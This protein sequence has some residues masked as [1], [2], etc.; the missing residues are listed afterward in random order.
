MTGFER[1]E[2]RPVIVGGGIAGLAAALFLAPEPVVL[3]TRAPLG[4]DGSSPLAQG[5]MAASVGTD[6][7][8][9]L[10]LADTLMAGDGLCDPEVARR[11]LADGPA[12]VAELER[13]GV[14]FD[15]A[16][17]GSLALGLEAAHSRRRIVHADG[18]ATG[19]ALVQALTLAAR[20]C[21]SITVVE[22]EA[23]R[24]LMEDGAVAGLLVAGRDGGAVL[25]TRRLI[26]ATGGVGALFEHTTNPASSFGVGL[27]LAADAG[28]ELA[29]LEFVQFHPTALAT[30]ARPL[31]LISEAVR[32][33][34][35][36]IVDRAGRRVL[37]AVPGAE[38]A[39]RDV[40]ARAV[41]R[42]LVAGREV[43]LDARASLGAR[44]A[45]RFP[46]VAAGCRAAGI[47]PATD[48]VPIRPAAHY[49]MG[50]I[51][52]D[53][54]GRSSVPGL[55]A[56]GEVAATGLH[57]ANRLA[58]NSL[59]EAV[60]C[61]RA[62][63]LSVAATPARA[64]ARLMAAHLPAAPDPT[65]VRPIVSRHLGVTRDGSGLASAIA[66]LLP[67]AEGTGPAAAPARVGLMMAVSALAREESRG[68]HARTDFPA[69]AAVARRSR[70]SLE[71]T[72][73]EARRH[74]APALALASSS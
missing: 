65:S 71:R 16:A 50:G 22:A 48:L 53:A 21:P 67:L 3:V 39:P 12:A 59:L 58:S 1:L 10:H 25:R 61:G 27:A 29:D 15:R 23:R 35:A 5:G 13:L 69:P 8:A 55:W 47:D 37:E 73:A 56:A 31:S 2:G 26:L 18:D 74:A 24:I 54:D 36:L 33:E 20:A 32:G 19:R 7:D 45:T 6:D 52:V 30:S 34:G 38:L 41:W 60:V 4:A 40:V 57:G 66:R 14:A 46:S 49:H 63:A 62:A 72:F 70:T 42:E 51:A 64:P 43:F 17:D 68:A 44:F 11:I 9:D 28:A